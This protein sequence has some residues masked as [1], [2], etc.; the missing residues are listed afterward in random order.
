M[1]SLVHQLPDPLDGARAD[2]IQVVR[3]VHLVPL[4]QGNV[5]LDFIQPRPGLTGRLGV[6]G[7]LYGLLQRR[8]VTNIV[9][10]LAKA[11]L[12]DGADKAVQKRY[13]PHDCAHNQH[14]DQFRTL[15]A[16]H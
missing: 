13:C 4:A 11:F 6:P 7:L 5:C 14:S 16:H 12:L 9:Y 10:R 15:C 3:R 1:Q 8:D 2:L